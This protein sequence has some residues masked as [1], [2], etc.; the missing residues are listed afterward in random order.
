[1]GQCKE[2]WKR[3]RLLAIGF[4]LGLSLLGASLCQGAEEWD[5]SYEDVENEIFWFSSGVGGWS[6]H[7][8]I[9][10]E[11]DFWGSYHDSDMGSTGEGYP[12]GTRYESD[13]RGSFGEAE[14]IDDYTY[15][16]PVSYLSTLK[17]EEE[18]RI[19]G[20]ILK[21]YSDP[22]GVEGT[23]SFLLYLPGKPLEKLPEQ[24]RG[25]V[26][27][28]LYGNEGDTLPFYGLYNEEREEGFSSYAFEVQEGYWKESLL[29]VKER[30]SELEASLMHEDLPQMSLN[31]LSG[32][33]YEVWDDYLN[34]IWAYLQ[35]EL[36]EEQMDALTEEEIDWI[37]D[38]EA[39]VEEAGSW[40]E[41]GSMQ[42]MLMN[43][44][45]GAWTKQ[46]VYELIEWYGR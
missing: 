28:A 10:S 25:W 27:G 8:F 9:G 32:E 22:Y 35:R 3:G 12:Y 31:E 36:S 13:F 6:T 37:Q 20:G 11:G 43:E 24:Y 14:K 45:A 23:E 38:K 40:A 16:L 21:V 4:F 17:E 42:P 46:R 7:L 18:E 2:G 26:G 29:D 33:L 30:A 44:A 1:M 34:D 15:R 39:A 41:G 19:Q 5:F